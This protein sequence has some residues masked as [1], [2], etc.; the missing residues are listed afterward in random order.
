MRTI[1][2]KVMIIPF[3]MVTTSQA[4]VGRSITK[5][6]RILNQAMKSIDINDTV[7]SVEM[8]EDGSLKVTFLKHS[9]IYVMEPI[10]A[11]VLLKKLESSQ[12]TKKPLVISVLPDNNQ[13]IHVE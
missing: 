12:S 6:D 8:L 4:M 13:I 2:F 7:R 5:Q 1:F 3:F 10:K 9:A 11:E